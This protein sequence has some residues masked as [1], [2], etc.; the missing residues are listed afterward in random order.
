MGFL[1]RVEK[2]LE[3]KQA[4]GSSSLMSVT[5]R[6]ALS[7]VGSVAEAQARVTFAIREPQGLGMPSL[8]AASSTADAVAGKDA[9]LFRYE[10]PG[11]GTLT[12]LERAGD[13][14]V[15]VRGGTQA[16]IATTATGSMVRWMENGV[17][18]T[19]IAERGTRDELLAAVERI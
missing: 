3:T 18:F 9:V 19:V 13:D 14:V 17:A 11:L 12:L 16:T 1:R 8:I 6:E 2:T 4:G 10:D 7:K 15:T 5:E